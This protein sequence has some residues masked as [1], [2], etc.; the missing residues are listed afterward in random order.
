MPNRPAGLHKQH[1]NRGRGEVP[2]P[3]V[4]FQHHRQYRPL[5]PLQ[6]FRN[7]HGVCRGPFA[8]IVTHAPERQTVIQ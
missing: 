2:P 7:L 6:I 3:E 1:P 5:L 4:P 8:E